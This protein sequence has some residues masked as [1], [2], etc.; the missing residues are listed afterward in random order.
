[1]KIVFVDKNK[2]LVEKVREL[3]E[4]LWDWNWMEF[5]T[6][7][8]DVFDYKKKNPDFKLCTASNPK[9]SMWGGLDFAIKKNYPN[10]CDN[11]KEFV[12]TDNLFPI[13]TVDDNIESS[14]SIIKRALAWIYAYRDKFNFIITGIGTAIWWLDESILLEELVNLRSADLSYADL[15]YANLTKTIS[16]E[17][18]ANFNINCPEEWDF[19]GWKKCRDWCIVKLLIPAKSKRSSATSRKCRAE[20]VK[21]L[22]IRDKKWKKIKEAISNHTKEVKYTVG[23]ITKC[24][25]WEDDRWIECAWGIHF[26]ITRWEAEQ[27]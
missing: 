18:T 20:F 7:C 5:S 10:E 27:W 12:W 13:I 1:M 17:M 21:T 19:I 15:S 4:K 22:E 23:K 11:L 6:H 9:F 14:R 25:V 2:W 16:N 3:F 8:W 24:D 26:F